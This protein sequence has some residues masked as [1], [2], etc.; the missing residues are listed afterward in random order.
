M[1]KNLEYYISVNYPMLIFKEENENYF[2][3][4]PDLP[5]CMSCAPNLQKAIEMGE[6]AKKCWIETALEE[7]NEIPEPKELDD[8]SGNFRIRMPKTLHKNLVKKAKQEGISMNQYCIY[9]LSKEFE[10]EHMGHRA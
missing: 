5:G 6:D 1:E 9:L 2:V 7:G 8:Y 3:E 4:Y 10:R